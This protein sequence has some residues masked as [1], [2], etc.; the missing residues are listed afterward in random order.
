L[1]RSDGQIVLA[2]ETCLAVPKPLERAFESWSVHLPDTKDHLLIHP[3]TKDRDTDP[4]CRVAGEQG[5]ITLSAIYTKNSHT[6]P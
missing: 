5:L 1:H 3:K 2:S 6:D 4:S